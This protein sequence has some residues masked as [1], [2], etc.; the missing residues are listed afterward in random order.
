MALVEPAD[1]AEHA[2]P[3]HAGLMQ[4]ATQTPAYYAR[5]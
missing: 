1:A 2:M 3:S 4:K 5:F